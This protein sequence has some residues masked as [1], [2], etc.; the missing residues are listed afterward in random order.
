MAQIVVA[1]HPEVDQTDHIQ[2]QADEGVAPHQQFGELGV[3][4]CGSGAGQQ[5]HSCGCV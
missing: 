5:S 4:L 2:Q 3:A 1:E